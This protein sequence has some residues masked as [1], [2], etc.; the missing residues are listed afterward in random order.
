MLRQLVKIDRYERAA[1][2]RR[3]RAI[4]AL[5]EQ[6]RLERRSWRFLP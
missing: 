6:H 2:A 5:A 3:Q 4:E 1:T